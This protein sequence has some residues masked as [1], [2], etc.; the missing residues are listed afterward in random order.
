MNRKESLAFASL[1]VPCFLLIILLSLSRSHFGFGTETD[2][3][4]G[5]LPEAQR[6]I[7]GEPLL[8]EFHPPL[9]SILLALVQ[10]ITQ[11]WLKT[12]LLISLAASAISLVTNFLF[13][14][15][16]LG[17]YAAWGAVLGL[18]AS[19]NF[20]EYSTYATSDIFFLAL[21]S[22]ALWLSLL[23]VKK[24]RA[25]LWILCGLAVGC[26]LITRTNGI[27]CLFIALLPW[28]SSSSIREKL[29]QLLWFFL[30]LFLPLI[31]WVCYAYLSGSEFTPAGTYANLAMTY[32]SPTADRM[33]GDSRIKVEAQF[34]SL[35]SV[36]LYDPVHLAKIYLK[37]L[38]RLAK[39][40]A[41]ML[42]NPLGL[43][44]L[45]GMFSFFKDAS[46]GTIKNKRLC[47]FYIVLT[48]V[49]ILLINFKAYEERY[50]LFFLPILGV[51]VSEAF[52]YIIYL[53][54]GRSAKGVSMGVCFFCG[55]LAVA[56]SYTTAW[57]TVSSISGELAEVVP[58]VQQLGISESNIITRKPHLPFYTRSVSLS[59]PDVETLPELRCAMEAQPNSQ[60]LLLY[61]GTQEKIFRR[62]F[63]ALA[64]PSASPDW[65]APIDQS[66]K[67]DTWALYRYIP[68]APG[69]KLSASQTCEA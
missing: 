44:V 69:A 11:D 62:Q 39:K 32:F 18:L 58:S 53:A 4:G 21:Y 15:Q 59:F 35:T 12:G 14:Y 37:D 55:L 57:K 9:Y 56:L 66:A 68:N 13:F 50:F 54:R 27:V 51:F 49:Q 22:V 42:Q 29:N 36:L 67:P 10:G 61:Y 26:L 63:K 16:L 38:L 31:A 48:I 3:L 40:T 28:W 20:I 2:Y 64:D 23:A 43:F 45:V 33:S 1:V 8:L 52:R 41:E 47:T 60:D 24:Q 5:F 19:D 30:G 46:K 34:D 7:S 25:Y 17:A 65:L 6:I